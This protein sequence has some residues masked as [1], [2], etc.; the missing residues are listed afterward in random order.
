M[1]PLEIQSSSPTKFIDSRPNGT[2]KHTKLC[3]PARTNFVNCVIYFIWAIRHFLIE[4]IR[5]EEDV[6]SNI[7]GE[8]WHDVVQIETAQ[9]VQHKCLLCELQLCSCV[10][11]ASALRGANV[12]MTT[13]NQDA[14]D[15]ALR[16][17]GGLTPK[18]TCPTSSTLT[19]ASGI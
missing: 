19:P 13:A 5:E 1:N 18:R 8:H 17:S 9:A 6:C 11:D 2:S 4:S 12:A 10:L 16:Q 14:I 3:S 15:L 7:A